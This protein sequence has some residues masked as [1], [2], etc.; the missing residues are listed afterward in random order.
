MGIVLGER[1]GQ[2][3]ALEGAVLVCDV[4]RLPERVHNDRKR[5]K[6]RLPPGWEVAEDDHRLRCP[7]CAKT[8]AHVLEHRQQVKATE[9]CRMALL[10]RGTQ[11]ET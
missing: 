1:F 11:C 2:H 3:T 8:H 4:C 6:A 9:A 7:S 5:G 10:R